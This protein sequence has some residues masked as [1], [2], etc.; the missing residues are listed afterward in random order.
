MHHS[1]A[2]EIKDYLYDAL[3]VAKTAVQM[4]SMRFLDVV[5]GTNAEVSALPQNAESSLENNSETLH[6]KAKHLYREASYK[7]NVITPFLEPSVQ[8]VIQQYVCL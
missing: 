1:K 8:P 3:A 4:D 5:G 6:S 2:N 7:L